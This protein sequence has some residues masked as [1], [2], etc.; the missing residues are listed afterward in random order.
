MKALLVALVLWLC[1]APA[2]AFIQPNERL[3]DPVAEARA[4]DLGNII[5][6]PVCD[7]Q[8]IN[9]SAS[10]IAVAMR[11]ALREKITAGQSDA[12]ILSWFRERYGQNIISQPPLTATTGVLWLMPVLILTLGGFLIVRQLRTRKKP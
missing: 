7:G 9:G 1:A 2:H 4:E 10:E 11:L 5:L 12:Q 8:A 3:P 6:C